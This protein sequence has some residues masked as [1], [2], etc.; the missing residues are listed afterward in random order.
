MTNWELEFLRWLTSQQTPWL[1]LVASVLTF[2]GGTFY[3][4]TLPVV[5]FYVSKKVGIRIFLLFIV[6]LYLNSLLRV[7][8]GVPRP[9][10]MEGVNSLFIETIQGDSYRDYSFPS[11]HAQSAVILW[12]YLAY[13]LGSKLFWMIACTMIS[14]ISFSR[15]YAGVHWLSDV[16]GGIVLGSV[17][18][19]TTL[20]AEPHLP[21]WS[22]QAGALF[23]AILIIFAALHSIH[24]RLILCSMLAGAGLGAYL[25]QRFV[26]MDTAGS[27]PM[28]AIGS[29]LFFVGLYG[30]NLAAKAL[31]PEMATVAYLL[32]F[33]LGFFCYFV[34]PWLLVSA[35][36]FSRQSGAGVNSSP[37][38]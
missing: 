38:G 17:F 23:I 14:L 37:H 13:H 2:L 8:W 10:G 35:G 33:M 26:R 25:E 30:L 21:R 34:T 1:N 3:F 4:M 9:V 28:K 5:Y 7:Y 31:P 11:G 27:K 32:N 29:L 24:D 36:A 12:G 20:R 19:V 18:L 22:V 15:V 16:I 6:S